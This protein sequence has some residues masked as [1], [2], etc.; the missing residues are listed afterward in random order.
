MLASVV[1]ARG[2]ARVRSVLGEVRFA[3]TFPEGS[4]NCPF[5]GA[6]VFPGEVRTHSVRAEV[7]EAWRAAGFAPVCGNP[8][9][10]AGPTTARYALERRA[11]REARAAREREW[12]ARTDA[13]DRYA[14][15][16]REREARL[17]A[18]WRETAERDGVCFTCL[19]ASRG[20]KRIS[21][22]SAE[23]HARRA[24]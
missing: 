15:A 19:R 3:R 24:A 16:A 8:V 12:R 22:R 18:E 20:A 6:A 23:Y 5:C 21:H 2:V 13:M 9:C 4:F 7:L 11:E 1:N 14:A 10:D 17:A